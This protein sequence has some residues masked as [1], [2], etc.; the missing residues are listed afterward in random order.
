MISKAFPIG[1]TGTWQEADQIRL[2]NAHLKNWLM[3][4][5]SLTERLQSVCRRFEVEVLGHELAPV[6]EEEH[7]ALY[8]D[9]SVARPTQVREVLLRGD[10]NAWVFAR[11]LMPQEFI[12][13]GIHELGNLGNQPLGKI[14]FNDPRFERQPF[15]IM[16]C[17]VN[18]PLFT[19]LGISSVHPLWGRR[20]LFH[21]QSYC[22]MVCEMFLPGAPA[23]RDMELSMELN[24][25][26]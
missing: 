7:R 1:I 2:P 24:N 9:T 6:T 10:D 16:H 11:S 4:T 22:I 26:E 20:S 21:F 3:D 23:Y 25:A 14:L 15:E 17:K 18:H 13:T 19:T 8:M 5:G 12:E